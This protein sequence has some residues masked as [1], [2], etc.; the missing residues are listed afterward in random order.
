MVAEWS[1]TSLLI[2]FIPHHLQF[3]NIELF[4]DRRNK[5]FNT[6]KES[7]PVCPFLFL[8]KLKD[9]KYVKDTQKYFIV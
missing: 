5:D 1:I 2:D 3:K 6:I 8:A 9:I 4:D 7:R